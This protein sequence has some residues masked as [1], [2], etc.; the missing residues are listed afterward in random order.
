MALS[1]TVTLV[2]CHHHL[3]AIFLILGVVVRSRELAILLL[4]IIPISLFF[5][6]KIIGSIKPQATD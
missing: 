1:V 2:A 3:P 5:R 6:N 4:F